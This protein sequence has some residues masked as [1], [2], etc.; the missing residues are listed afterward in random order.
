MNL[1]VGTFTLQTMHDCLMPS[2]SL[3]LGAEAE[4]VFLIDIHQM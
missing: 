4:A 3:I 2:T 1:V